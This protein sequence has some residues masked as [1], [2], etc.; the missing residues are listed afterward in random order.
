MFSL[1]GFKFQ[2]PNADIRV[3]QVTQTNELFK[4]PNNETNKNIEI[5][6]EQVQTLGIQGDQEINKK[7]EENTRQARDKGMMV[8]RN[9]WEQFTGG[10]NEGRPDNWKSRVKE[11]RQEVCIWNTRAFKVKPKDNQPTKA[12]MKKEVNLETKR[13]KQTNEYIF[14]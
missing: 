2:A 6:S 9:R 14:S 1:V 5:I 4:R 8:K 12:N 3:G 10:N 7:T 11:Q 13:S